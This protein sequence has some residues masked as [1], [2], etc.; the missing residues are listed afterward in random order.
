[1]QPGTSVG[2][3]NDRLDEIHQLEMTVNGR[4]ETR[5]QLE[6]SHSSPRERGERRQ[7]EE[8]GEGSGRRELYVSSR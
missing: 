2:E 5:R 8:R 7:G 3:D 1:M 4:R 6:N